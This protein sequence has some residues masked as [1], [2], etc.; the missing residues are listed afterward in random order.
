M[1][2]NV[3]LPGFYPSESNLGGGSISYVRRRALTNGSNPIACQDAV[4]ADSNAD[5]LGLGTSSTFATAVD[6]VAMG[7]SYIA[8]DGTR[9]ARANLPGSTAYTSTGVDPINAT[10]VFVTEAA[11]NIKYLCS[12]DTA[13]ALTNIRNNFDIN[14][15]A[16]VN[17][18]S[19][20]ELRAAS[21]SGA[22]TTTPFRL[23]DFVFA[24]DNIIDSGTHVHVKAMINIGQ[25]EPD[26]TA[27]TP[28]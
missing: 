6:G 14:L 10:Y 4:K 5:I 26:M 21:A 17:G 19:Q 8:A 27:S 13:M 7:V 25:T 22:T 15:A 16:G 2:T 11:D 3:A 12:V 24:G 18:Y 23:V 28:L 20:Q 1:A 9:V